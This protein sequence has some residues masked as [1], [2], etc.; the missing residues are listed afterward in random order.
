MAISPT[1]M[2]QRSRDPTSHHRKRIFVRIRNT[3]VFYMKN[4]K[5]LFHILLSVAVNVE[6]STFRF[7]AERDDFIE[8]IAIVVGVWKLF[9]I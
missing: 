7:N 4:E 9:A 6:N 5:L 3:W 8:N 2:L 1:C